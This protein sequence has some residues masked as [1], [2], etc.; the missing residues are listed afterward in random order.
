MTPGGPFDS[1]GWPSS[2]PL[3][4]R[5]SGTGP[6]VVLVHGR[7]PARVTWACQRVLEAHWLLH[8]S[9]SSRLLT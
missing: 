7:L 9:G 5:R 2:A 1:M 3:F 4:T 8:R 6:P